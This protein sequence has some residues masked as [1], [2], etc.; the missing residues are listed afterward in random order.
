MPAVLDEPFAEIM[1]VECPNVKQ[2][3][4]PA[5]L[6]EPFA[7]IGRVECPHVRRNAN[8]ALAR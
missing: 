2:I 4:N 7:D 6:D 5:V 8:F 1:P 3:A